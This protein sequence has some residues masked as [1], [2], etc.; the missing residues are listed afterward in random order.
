MTLLPPFV[1]IAGLREEGATCPHCSDEVTYGNECVTCETCGTVHHWPCWQSAGRCGS[2]ECSAGSQAPLVAQENKIRI[3]GEDLQRAV[4]LPAAR[5]LSVGTGPGLKIPV[6]PHPEEFR[7][8]KLAIASFIVALLGIPLFG[9]VTGLVALVLGALALV[10][11]NSFRRKGLPL[12]V[13][14][15]VLGIADFVGWMVFL[16]SKVDR[17]Q[18]QIVMDELEPDAEALTQL[19]AAINRAMKANVLI[20]TGGLFERGLGS[21]VILSITDGQAL[22]VTNRHVVD[23]DFADGGGSTLEDLAEVVVKAIGQPAAI[24]KTVWLAPQK[25]DLALVT[26]PVV[27]AEAMQAAWQAAPAV[28]VGD[29]VFAIGNPHGLGWSHTGGDVSQIRRQKQDGQE[30]RVIQTSAAINPGNSGGGLYDAAGHLIGI[31]TWTGDKRTAEGLGFAIMF[32]TLLSVVPD[33]FSIPDHRELDDI[34]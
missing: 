12:A 23:T 33:Q 17:L 11:Q 16:E 7:W 30:F 2:Y 18:F 22:I 4:P 27:S 28:R 34:P 8:N 5:P 19:P 32:E 9:I 3:S 13:A 31:N 25:V 20:Q 21:G 15:I 24:G 14:G 26:A 1:R 6:G 10:G 29:A